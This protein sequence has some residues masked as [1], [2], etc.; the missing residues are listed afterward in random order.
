LTL[1]AKRYAGIVRANQ[2]TLGNFPADLTRPQYGLTFPPTLKIEAI[3]KV[4]I[5]RWRPK[6]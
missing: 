4:N 5:K 1:N 2:V 6:T 3:R